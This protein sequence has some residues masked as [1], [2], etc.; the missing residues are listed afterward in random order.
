MTDAATSPLATTL[1]LAPGDRIGVIN[2]PA[3]LEAWLEP[4]P[5]GAT[6]EPGVRSHRDVV[7]AFLRLRTELGQKRIAMAKAIEPDGVLWVVWP[8]GPDAEPTDLDETVVGEIVAPSGLVPTEVCALRTGW[9]AVR[10]VLAPP[11]PD[12]VGSRHG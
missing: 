1:G 4:L 9:S 5:A 11:A 7:L 3:Q 12:A 10:L 6:L 8:A 2:P